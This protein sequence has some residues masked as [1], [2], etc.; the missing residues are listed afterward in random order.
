M[1]TAPDTKAN[2]ESLSD[3]D[4][5]QIWR[6]WPVLSITSAPK[7]I[8]FARA[9]LAADR[10]LTAEQ[11]GNGPVL[12]H[13]IYIPARQHGYL[14]EDLDEA[15]DDLTNCACEV[16][17]LVAAL[18]T[19]PQAISD[20]TVAPPRECSITEGPRDRDRQTA[21][22][23]AAEPA[24]LNAAVDMML[25]HIASSADDCLCAYRER[26]IDRLKEELDSIKRAV[27]LIRK[28]LATAPTEPT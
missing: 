2:S 10:R 27:E 8:S 5:A 11:G 25:A 6:N 15:I 13:Y 26:E 14:V 9:I 23:Q 20:P 19:Q 17:P 3:A 21:Q 18:T 16:T 28:A 24:E 22:P 12:G 1:N 4:I 7:A